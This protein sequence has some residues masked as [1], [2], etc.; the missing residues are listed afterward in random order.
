[1]T[2]KA[3]KHELRTTAKGNLSEGQK[4]NKERKNKAE[5]LLCNIFTSSTRSSR[6]NGLNVVGKTLCSKSFT[7]DSLVMVILVI[8]LATEAGHFVE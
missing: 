1:M 2:S 8:H 5:L 4:T 7:Y 6:K 3:N